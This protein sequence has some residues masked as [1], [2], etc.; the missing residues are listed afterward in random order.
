[1]DSRNHVVSPLDPVQHGIAEDSIEFP[2]IG[3]RHSVDNVR[4]QAKLARRID[5]CG[6]RID[7]HNV[8]ADIRDLFSQNAVAA[9]QIKY[10]FTRLGS[11]K[12][13]HR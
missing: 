9:P 5:E 3:Q 1:M 2:V 13:Q 10:A 11:Q 12:F 7:R 8:A 6:T 4:N